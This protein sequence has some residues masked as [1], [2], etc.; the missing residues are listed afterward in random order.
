[1]SQGSQKP[2][3]KLMVLVM[4]VSALVGLMLF[5]TTA[6]VSAGNGT[7]DEILV[8]N[9]GTNSN[10]FTITKA[11]NGFIMEVPSGAANANWVS[12]QYAGFA[13]GTLYYRARIISIPQNQNRMKFG[14]CVWQDHFKN[15]EC[16]GQWLTGVPGAESTWSHKLSDM[17]VKKPINWSQPR[18]RHGFIVRN[19]Q[20]NPVSSK[21][22]WNWSGENPDHWYP[23]NVHYTVVLVKQGG[24]F[25][26]WEN[27]GW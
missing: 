4:F 10:P 27:Y 2:W 24:T 11:M 12:G 23:M 6:G 7:A 14:F 9:R 8:Y 15:E 21:K 20:N 19:A 13:G 22:N 1:M 16:R 26:G 3:A 18:Q 5:S 25:D 17:W